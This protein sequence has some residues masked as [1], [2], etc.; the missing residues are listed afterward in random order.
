[1]ES[2]GRDDSEIS[3][4]ETFYRCGGKKEP[5]ESELR[6][7]GTSYSTL[8]QVKMQ[9]DRLWY[10][11]A[12]SGT[13]RYCTVLRDR[14]WYS[15]TDYKKSSGVGNCMYMGTETAELWNNVVVRL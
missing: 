14:R 3:S 15:G 1:L 6:D 11:R 12:G 5:G 8:K 4:N 13:V 10:S 9:W 7:S 2:K